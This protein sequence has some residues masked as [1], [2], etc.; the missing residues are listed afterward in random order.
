MRVLVTGSTGAIGGAVCDEL[1][2]AGHEVRGFDRAA[3]DSLADTRVG[4]LTDAAAVAAAAEGVDVIVHLAATPDEADFASD[5]LPN[6]I[7]GTYHVLEAAVQ[8]HVPRVVLT[9]SSLTVHSLLRDPAV[10]KPIR[11]EDGYKTTLHYGLS[12]I[13]L[14]QAGVM[15]AQK[16]NMSVVS[17]RPG[18]MP[19]TREAF[20][21]I[22]QHEDG[23]KW[24]LSPGDAGRCFRLAVEGNKPAP[25]HAAAVFL[26]SRP[27]SEPLLDMTA[28][29]DVLGFEPRDSWPDGRE[30]LE[31]YWRRI[32]V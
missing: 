13:W 7:L 16:H 23:R 17:I 30:A 11:I 28:A 21:S 29:R 14:E 6:N 31:K 27:D 24:Y 5:I 22:G 9:S 32:G 25:G 18:H 26:T 20:E 15:Y 12:K 4:N 2:A 10:P 19:R 1:L 8:H 3:S